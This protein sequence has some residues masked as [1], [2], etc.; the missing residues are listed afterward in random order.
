MEEFG[1]AEENFFRQF[2]ELPYGIPD[3]RAVGRIFA[4]MKPAELMQCLVG[5]NPV[6]GRAINIDGE[7]GNQGG[8]AASIVSV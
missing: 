3:D 4:R 1:K 5:V 7:R 8:V 2:L 6:R